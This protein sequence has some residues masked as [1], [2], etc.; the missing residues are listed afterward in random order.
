VKANLTAFVSGL[1]FAVGLGV[2]GMT[3]PRNIVNFLDVTGAWDARLLILMASAVGVYHAAYHVWL[4]RQRTPLL[5][6]QYALPSVRDIDGR[7]LG[8][9]ALFGA[10]WGLAGLCPGPALTSLPGGSAAVLVFVAGMAGGIYA[11][12]LLARQRTATE[13]D[14]GAAQPGKVSA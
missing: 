9:A 4:H 7:L 12:A 5:G 2:G 11:F 8:G 10:G 1:L 13:A 6:Q 14:A 3:D